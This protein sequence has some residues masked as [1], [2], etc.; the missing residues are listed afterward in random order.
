[1]TVQFHFSANAD[2]I[3]PELIYMY[4]Y[5]LIDRQDAVSIPYTYR[6]YP[7]L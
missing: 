5:I 3:P 7:N 1:M 6:T 2:C 4:M